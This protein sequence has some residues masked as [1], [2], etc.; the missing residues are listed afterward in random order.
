MAQIIYEESY[1]N[2]LEEGLYT[3]DQ[4]LDMLIKNNLWDSEKEKELETTKKDIDILKE[5]LFKRESLF[6]IPDNLNIFLISYK[7]GRFYG[8]TYSK[9]KIL[10]KTC[11]KFNSLFRK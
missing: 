6:Y 3:D 2:A 4:I 10:L 1:K 8:F 7:V 9:P 11:N 5:E